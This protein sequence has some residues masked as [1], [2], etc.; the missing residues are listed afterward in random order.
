MIGNNA[1]GSRALKYGSTIDNVEQMTFVDGQGKKITLPDNK[2]IGNEILKISKRINR[3]RFPHVSKNSCGY[4]LDL[5][6]SIND[7]HKAIVGAEGTLGIVLSAKI[8]I[9]KI[10]EKRFLFI[11]GYESPKDAASDCTEIIKTNPS[12]IEFVDKKTLENI[13]FR[14]QKN[15]NCLL[16]VE[17]DENLERIKE[18]QKANSGRIVKKISKEKEIEKWW[19]YR[20]LALSFSLKSIK[21]KDRVPHIIEDAAVPI[22]KLVDLFSLIEKI[23]KEFQTRTIMYGHAGN[24]NIHVR[25]VSDRKR[26]KSLQKISEI[27]F[28]RVIKMGGTIT[29]E[30]GDGIAR[31]DFIQKQ[32]G[33]KN[34]LVFKALKKILDPKNILNPGKI[35]STR[36][37][38]K[39]LENFNDY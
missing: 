32:Y 17:Y 11:L 36:R 38:Q 19:K 31:S 39:N 1:S 2:K 23:S 14:F 27:Y 28:D 8:S 21:M 33:T 7:T 37:S 25:I 24:G 10:P 29:G 34:Y 12:A 30:H 6:R 35:T 13:D 5:V 9:K 16:F 15:V 4:R 20:D 22:S 18:F 3:E 26:I